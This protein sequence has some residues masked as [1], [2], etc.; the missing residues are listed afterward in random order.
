[1]YPFYGAAIDLVAFILSFLFFGGAHGPSGPM[2]MLWVVNRPM[3]ELRL[4]LIDTT[5][6]STDLILAI[7]ALAINGA[8][9]GA[10]IAGVVALWRAVFRHR[11]TRN[12]HAKRLT[13]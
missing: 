7:V 10:L 4:R 9:Y 13:Q 5:S 8:I 6:N 3:S 2:F 12:V 1:M 11:A